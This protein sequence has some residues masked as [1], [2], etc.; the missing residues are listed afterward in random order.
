LIFENLFSSTSSELIAPSAGRLPALK[1]AIFDS[2]SN[3][4]VSGMARGSLDQTIDA[5]ATATF[6]NL[7]IHHVGGSILL[8]FLIFFWAMLLAPSGT[9]PCIKWV[10]NSSQD[11]P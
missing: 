7:T 10:I 3:R 4:D 6:A 5:N 11:S 2:S 8:W 1:L 9:F